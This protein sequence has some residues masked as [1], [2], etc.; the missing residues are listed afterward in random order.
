MKNLVVVLLLSLTTLVGC[1]GLVQNGAER[2]RR[3]VNITK[4][5]TKMAVDDWDTIWLYDRSSR[6][7]QWHPSVGVK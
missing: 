6:L 1:S 2:G 7:T 3:Y 5:Q 4:L